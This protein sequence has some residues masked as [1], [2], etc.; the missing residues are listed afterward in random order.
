MMPFEIGWIL[1]S[2][3]EYNNSFNK[4]H[5]VA[6]KRVLRYLKGTIDTKICYIKDENENITGYCDADFASDTYEGKSVTGYVFIMQGGAITWASKKQPIVALSTTEAEYM[7]IGAA[8]QECLWLQSLEG[9]LFKKPKS[10]T[11]FSD[12]QSA[13]HLASN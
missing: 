13:I 8:T 5:W 1:L 10:T 11:L 7:S 6:V 4:Q 2:L 12:N 9:E 3:Y